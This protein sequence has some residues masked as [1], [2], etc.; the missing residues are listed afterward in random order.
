MP[1]VVAASAAIEAPL[2]SVR[3][4]IMFLSLIV[5]YVLPQADFAKP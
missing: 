3:R 4:A 2:M 1:D 5:F